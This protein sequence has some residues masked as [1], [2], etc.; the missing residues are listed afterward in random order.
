MLSDPRVRLIVDDGRRYLFNTTRKF[1]MITTDPLWSFTSHANNLYSQEFYR[2]VQDHL[3]PG[4][5]FM[6]WQDEHRIISKTLASVFSHLEKFR[7]FS[8]ASDAPM[9]I[10]QGRREGLLGQFSPA[11][12]ERILVFAVYVGDRARVEAM[13]AR[14]PVNREWQPWT[15]YYLGRQYLEWKLRGAP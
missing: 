13:T 8:I 14:F 10:N 2:L 12:R 6:A 15:E 4:G 9:A 11:D 1:D 3:A 7:D 5:V